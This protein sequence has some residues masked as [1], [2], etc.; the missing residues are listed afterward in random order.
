MLPSVVAN[1]TAS[2]PGA[3][4]VL[5]DRPLSPV[6]VVLVDEGAVVDAELEQAASSSASVRTAIGRRSRRAMGRAEGSGRAAAGVGAVA[7]AGERPTWRR[8]RGH[9]GDDEPSR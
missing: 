2:G 8:C 5:V 3:A 4:V 9:T 1:S 6:A 7:E